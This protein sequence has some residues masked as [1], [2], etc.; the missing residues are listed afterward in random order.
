LQDILNK[1]EDARRIIRTGEASA[2]EHRFKLEEL[3]KVPMQRVLKYPLIVQ[4]LI[5]KSGENHPDYSALKDV[6]DTLLD[7]N[8]YINKTKFD[9]ER[10]INPMQSLQVKIDINP[11][12]RLENKLSEYGG[13]LFDGNAVKWSD[14]KVQAPNK[15]YIF[16]LNLA[17][18]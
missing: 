13:L 16:V 12:I 6:L 14:Y 8:Q 3:I 7:L 18:G 15:I 11:K 2:S 17:L 1:N 5:Q 9:V 10:T 4:R